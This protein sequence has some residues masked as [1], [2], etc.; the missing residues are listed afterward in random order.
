VE[1]DTEVMGA[2]A[3]RIRRC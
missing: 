1:A 3:V 2:A